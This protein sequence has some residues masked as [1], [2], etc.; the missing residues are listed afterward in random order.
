MMIMMYIL[1]MVTFIKQRWCYLQRLQTQEHQLTALRR[2]L[3]EAT[4]TITTLTEQLEGVGQESGANELEIR[5]QTLERELEMEIQ[6]R[7]IVS[8][9]HMH[10]PYTYFKF[11]VQFMFTAQCTRTCALYI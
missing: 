2:E 11:Y 10:V 8:L 5:I 7:K 1:Y 3:T 9:T 6:R 4:H